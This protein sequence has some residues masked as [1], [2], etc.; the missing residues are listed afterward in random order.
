[1][2]E[3]APLGEFERIRRYFRPLTAGSPGALD[4]TVAELQALGKGEVSGVRCDV[5]DA[6]A[7]EDAARVAW[8]RTGGVNVVCLNAGVFAGGYGQRRLGG[9]F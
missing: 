5:S 6:K 7:V 1:M 8:E 9:G 2:P 4:L 3:P